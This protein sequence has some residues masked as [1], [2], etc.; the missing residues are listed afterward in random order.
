M[1]KVLFNIKKLINRK[2]IQTRYWLNFRC[3]SMNNFYPIFNFKALTMFN[4]E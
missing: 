3:V 2:N 1:G 4:L